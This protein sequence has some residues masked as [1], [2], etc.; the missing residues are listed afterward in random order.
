MTNGK[1]GGPTQDVA[2]DRRVK[3]LVALLTAPNGVSVDKLATSLGVS[4]PAIYA[5]VKALGAENINGR[6]FMPKELPEIWANLAA[7]FETRQ[8]G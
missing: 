7:A 5:Q 1:A 2:L 3:V 6:W 8:N 4:R